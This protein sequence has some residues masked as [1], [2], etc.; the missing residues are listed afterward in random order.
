[1]LRHSLQLSKADMVPLYRGHNFNRPVSMIVLD[2]QRCQMFQSGR[3]YACKTVLRSHLEND[4]PSVSISF[5]FGSKNHVETFKT[6]GKRCD[7]MSSAVVV[8]EKMRSLH[9]TLST[10]STHKPNMHDVPLAFS[11]S[12]Y[13]EYIMQCQLS[14]Q[15]ILSCC[16]FGS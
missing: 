5:E 14:D 15:T 8:T 2:A 9:T 1:M 4:M 16:S 13:H 11:R 12:P 6:R 10:D 3:S 7:S